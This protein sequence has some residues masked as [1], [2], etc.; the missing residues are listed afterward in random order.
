MRTEEGESGRGG[1]SWSGSEQ[2]VQ[3][4]GEKIVGSGGAGE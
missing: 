1:G 2:G 4:K 3:N